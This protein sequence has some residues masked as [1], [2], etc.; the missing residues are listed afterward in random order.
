MKGIDLTFKDWLIIFFI[1][2]LLASSCFLYASHTL[3]KRFEGDLKSQSQQSLSKIESVSDEVQKTLQKLNKLNLKNC[4]DNAL[5]IMQQH[6]FEAKF[7]KEIAFFQGDKLLCSTGLEKKNSELINTKPDYT[8]IRGI[9]VWLHTPLYLFDYKK[10]GLLG[11]QQNFSVLLSNDF[12]ADLIH[13]DAE[14]EIIFNGNNS[15]IHTTGT[16]GLYQQIIANSRS[17][18]DH[19]NLVECAKYVPYCV[20]ISAPKKLFY[21]HYNPALFAWFAFSSLVFV[22]CF[23][24]LLLFFEKYRSLESRVLRGMKNNSFY[25]V[26]Q[27]VVELKTN[28][29]VGCEVLARFK[30]PKGSLSPADFIPIILSKGRTWEFTKLIIDKFLRDVSIFAEQ[31]HDFKINFNFFAQDI[32]SGAILEVLDENWLLSKPFTFVIEVTEDEKLSN[33][34]S[35]EVLNKL[36]SHGFCIAIDDFGTGYSNLR[37]LKEFPC[38]II[39]IDKTFISEM[40]D[41]SIRS[42]LIPHIVSIS[43]TLNVFVVAEGI[44]HLEQ[45]TALIELGVQ[46]GQGYLFGKPMRAQDFQRI[47]F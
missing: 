18:K 10:S 3:Q 2:I 41:G 1:S 8:G 46:Y 17:L 37:E 32:D 34:S 40:E 42:S 25:C 23:V 19:F 9:E 4:D 38:S 22:I 12:L 47:F 21:Q 30:D 5:K 28:R 31:G 7:I 44:E 20:A 35:V 45:Q 29:L 6:V 39:K 33:L 27:P 15:S 36:E 43:N 16:K 11:R 14:W 26:Y 24:F 13:L